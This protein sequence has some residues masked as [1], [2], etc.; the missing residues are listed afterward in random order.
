MCAKSIGILLLIYVKQIS[1]AKVKGIGEDI[2]EL[3]QS[4]LYLASTN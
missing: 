4:E 3:I 2:R 1:K